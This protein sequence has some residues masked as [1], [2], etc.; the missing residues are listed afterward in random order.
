MTCFTVRCDFV[1]ALGLQDELVNLQV[2]SGLASSAR[3]EKKANVCTNTCEGKLTTFTRSSGDG[4]ESTI[5][6]LDGN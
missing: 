2:K 5:Q 1:A 4:T 3:P 6:V